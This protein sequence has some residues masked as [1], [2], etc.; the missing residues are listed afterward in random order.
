MFS[1]FFGRSRRW[2]PP[3]TPYQESFCVVTLLASSA[4]PQRR[5]KRENNKRNRFNKQNKN[6][7]GAANSIAILKFEERLPDM[8]HQ[9]I[10]LW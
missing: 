10:T 8:L 5:R 4:Q 7:E 2:V 6:Y 1:T 9:R 3:T